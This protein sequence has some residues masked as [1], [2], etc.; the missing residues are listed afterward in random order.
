M[1]AS[2]RQ[3]YRPLL[4][5]AL[6]LVALLLPATPASAGCGEEYRG[7]PGHSSTPGGPP[8]AVGDSVLADAV[9]LL[10]REGFQA[11]GMVCRQMSQGL[12]L[13]KQRAGNLP[14]LVVLALGTNGEVSAAQIQTALQILG[15][16]RILA[17]VTPHGSVVPSSPQVIRSA[18]ERHPGK[19]LLLDWDRLVKNHP[20]W[21]APDGVHL[22]GSAGITGFA[23]LL[24][25]ALP[26]SNGSAAAVPAPE[27]S[28]QS[29]EDPGTPE[30]IQPAPE[31]RQAVK[32]V[33][34][35][36]SAN[37]S[38][39]S[40]LSRAALAPP[41]HAFVPPLAKSRPAGQVTAQTPVVGWVLLI[42][43]LFAATGALTF[44]KRKGRSRVPAAPGKKE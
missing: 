13:L 36:A 37:P 15:P 14:H 33:H 2:A 20:D 1:H 35:P 27:P 6:S 17:L 41:A 9:P 40:A 42:L 10:A 26:Y 19:I 38:A 32:P 43:V 34:P 7:G 8:L 4:V 11:D 21:L 12:E 25:R 22:G 3:L 30:T 39:S 18:A 24:S 28:E 44:R 31:H 5:G 29:S 16:S 23:E